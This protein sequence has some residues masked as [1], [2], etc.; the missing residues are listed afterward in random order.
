MKRIN[1]W[2]AGVL[3]VV[4]GCAGTDGGS[5]GAGTQVQGGPAGAGA[6]EGAGGGATSSD[7]EGAG[8]GGAVAAGAPATGAEGAGA[9]GAGTGAEPAPAG[10]DEPAEPPKEG[11]IATDPAT[12]GDPADPAAPGDPEDPKDPT[13]PAGEPT[14]PVGGPTDPASGEPSPL[15]AAHEWGTFT[16]VQ[17]SDG[18]ALWGLHHEEEPLPDFV[19]SRSGIASSQKGLEMLPEEVDQKLETPVIY[20]YAPGPVDV[21]V[22]VDF[23]KGVIGQWFPAAEEL[24]PPIYQLTQI[25]GGAM[26]WKV[27]LDPAIDPGLFPAVDPADIWAPSR[28]VAAT[29]LRAQG[30]HER[31]IFYRGLGR[32]SVPVRVQ[33][34]DGEVRITNDGDAPLEGVMLLRPGAD[35]GSFALLGALGPGQTVTHPEAV[36][37][38]SAAWLEGAAEALV[39]LLTAT[40]LYEDEARAMVDTWS[41]SWFEAGSLRVL[42]IVPRPWTDAL[43]PL[44]LEPTPK[45]LVR[46]LVGRIEVL[47]PAEEASLVALVQSNLGAPE[48]AVASLG[49]F[50]EPKLRRACALLTDPAAT[51]WCADVIPVVAAQ[52]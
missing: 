38:P 46:T 51:K 48:L 29:P 26:T 33:T 52:P 20:F 2:M 1:G 31:F 49:R 12:P 6:L 27:A 7:G 35:G 24:A 32:F 13:A 37:E 42:Y 50:A 4:A 8:S 39:Q 11:P 19:I 30:Q 22:K 3:V 25:A 14:D 34:V 43:L 28:N 10:V 16:S 40:G 18:V 23:P 41:R 45:E 17:G 5:E 47:T 21:T 15:L 36:G 9:G 44:T